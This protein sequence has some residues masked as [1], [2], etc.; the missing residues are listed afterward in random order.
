VAAIAAAGQRL[1]ATTPEEM[2]WR[3]VLARARARQRHPWWGWP[4]KWAVAFT[5]AA[6]C[7]AAVLALLPAPTTDYRFKGSLD[8]QLIVVRDG[9]T[10]PEPPERF[11]AN[12]R[13]SIVYQTPTDGFATLFW[14]DPTGACKRLLPESTQVVPVRAKE[15]QTLPQSLRLDAE[16]GLQ[17]LLLVVSPAADTE[18]T[19]RIVRNALTD[20]GLALPSGYAGAVWSIRT[21]P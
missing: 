3:T 4:A 20:Q 6:A 16:P 13:L 12:D 19:E 21:D 14:V 1:N 9:T 15:K 17:R 10:L 18:A 11:R 2:A 7:I 5:A 8:A